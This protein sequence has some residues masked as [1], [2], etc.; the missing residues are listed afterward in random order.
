V[1]ADIMPSGSTFETRDLEHVVTTSDRWFRPVDIKS[2]PDGAIYIVDWH[3]FSVNHWRNYQ[4]NMDAT[5]GRVWRLRARDAKPGKITDFTRLTSAALLDLLSNANR[6]IRETAVRE[7]AIRGDDAVLPRLEKLLE[8]RPGPGTLPAFWAW[9]QL[10]APDARRDRFLTHPAWQVRQWAVRTLGDPFPGQLDTGGAGAIP[11]A[12]LDKLANLAASEPNI[13]VRAQLAATA[14]RLPAD[15]A[16]P[17]IKALALRNEDARDSRQSLA[18]WW[19][20]EA[21]TTERPD[22]VAALFEDP[23]LWDATIVRDHLLARLMRRQAQAGSSA[24]LQTCTRL[25]QLS[26]SKVHSRILMGGFEAAYEGRAMTGLPDALISAM[27][28]HDVGSVAIGLRRGD[29]KALQEALALIVD[30]KADPT[31]RHH[32]IRILGEIKADAG[33]PA[34]LEL[35]HKEPDGKVLQAVF[36]AL[37]PF[38]A[39]GTAEAAIRRL[40]TLAPASRTAALTLLT[41]RPEF[42][43]ALV[44]AVDDGRVPADTVAP[45]FARKL[46]QLVPA[47]RLATI[48][49]LWPKAGRPTSLQM[50][51][52]IARLTTALADGH[53]DPYRGKD[54]YDRSCAACHRMFNKGGD[55]GPDLTSFDRR[56][57]D[58]L[59]LAVVNPSAEIREGYENFMIHTKDQRILGG[60]IV[61]QDKRQ[62]ILRGFDGQNVVLPRDNIASLQSA[63]MSL[64]PEGL[65]N[66]LEEQQV[67]DL[68][69]YLRSSQP[70]NQ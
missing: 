45:E 8:A 33:K 57:H 53:G 58:A 7:L 6:W 62:V 9:H 56:D 31:K 5:G 3:D 16:L 42:A 68:F 10:A 32:I 17:V 23:T 18:I 36:A 63:G 65:T 64:M 44:T 4:G 47:E 46:K 1:L 37:Q 50:D 11:P 43:A 38:H 40:P 70:L 15:A 67:R 34:L 26:P 54:L 12:N 52:E 60:F 25:F 69:A 48:D 30:R 2:G 28:R 39:D 24:E 19:A 41:S 22:A 29:P 51:R 55:I 49:R 61:S 13:E 14:R 35:A 20:L 66:G 27:A 21:K 59:L